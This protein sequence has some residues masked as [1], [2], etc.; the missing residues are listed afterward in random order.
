M[1]RKPFVLIPYIGTFLVVDREGFV[2]ETIDSKEKVSLPYVKGIKF[3]NYEIGQ[4]V[5]IENIEYFEKLIILLDALTEEEKD[6]KFKLIDNIDTIDISDVNNIY[7]LID[8]RLV[9]NI[10]DTFN[11][12]Y[13]IRTLKQILYK[14]IGNDETGMLDFTT[15]DYPVFIPSD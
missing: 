12:N 8:S 7:M 2:L 15:G 13:R 4:A 1:E 14:Y 9:V 11:L 3:S 6:D 5:K 10:G